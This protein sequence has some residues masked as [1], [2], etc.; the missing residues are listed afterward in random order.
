LV[1]RCHRNWISAR[2]TAIAG[3]E[4]T[5]IES[6]LCGV[7]HAPAELHRQSRQASRLSDSSIFDP[8]EPLSASTASNG[9][10]ARVAASTAAN[11]GVSPRHGAVK[12]RQRHGI[13]IGEDARGNDLQPSA[14]VSE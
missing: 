2:I 8:V 14:G 6:S 12:E 5:T 3:S 1:S 7:K 13:L 11:R 10:A 9:H 4:L